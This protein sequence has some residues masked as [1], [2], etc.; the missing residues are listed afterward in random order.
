LEYIQCQHCQ[1]RYNVND[2][3]RAAAGRKIR[4]KHCQKAFEIIIIDDGNK[5]EQPEKKEQPARKKL[6]LQL[7]ISIVLGFTL[8]CMSAGAYLYFYKPELFHAPEQ[9][10]PQPII[11]HNLVNPMSIHVA[12]SASEKTKPQADR[13][14]RAQHATSSPTGA[15][16]SLQVCKDAAAEYWLRT[17][18]L[19]TTRL[20]SDIYVK[21]LNMNLAQADE[22]RRICKDKSLVGKI[23]EAART[24][25]KP[26]WIKTEIESQLASQSVSPV[27]PQKTSAPPTNH[28]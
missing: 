6:N 21:L 24:D 12:P 17:R 14:T 2:K 8:I 5:P 15:N 18:L 13:K 1:K 26:S 25:K 27:T 11:P 22:I 16:P 7:I 19:A 28:P 9:Q 20:D 23:S 4:C 3:L 10:K